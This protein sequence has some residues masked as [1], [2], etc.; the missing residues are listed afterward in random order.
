MATLQGSD[1]SW[2]ICLFRRCQALAGRADDPLTPTTLDQIRLLVEDI[3]RGGLPISQ[4]L[5]RTTI[6]G[7]L[8][9]C[10]RGTA[11]DVRADLTSV[12]LEFTA[13]CS[14]FDGFR[15]ECLALIDRCERA[16]DRRRAASADDAVH[17]VLGVIEARYRE[18]TLSLRTVSAEVQLSISH[19]SRLLNRDLGCSFRA[20]LNQLRVSHAQRLLLTS[21]LS[22]KEVAATV[23]Y[24]NTSQLDRHLREVCGTTPASYR[25]NALSSIGDNTADLAELPSTA[26]AD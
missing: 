10:I 17:R 4:F 14:D 7:V 6:A 9:R 25:R 22:I 20:H 8:L 24:R 2:W 21:T 1:N 18:A 16:L 15:L 13:G 23:G 3:P 5:I 19:L 26:A 11:V 12:L